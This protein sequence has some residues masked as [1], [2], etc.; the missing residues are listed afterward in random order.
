M[1]SLFLII[2]QDLHTVLF[3]KFATLIGLN[4]QREKNG[5]PIKFVPIKTTCENSVNA[6]TR[7]PAIKRWL[8]F[9]KTTC[10]LLDPRCCNV[11][12]PKP[13]MATQCFL[14]RLQFFFYVRSRN[15]VNKIS[16]PLLKKAFKYLCQT[17]FHQWHEMNKQ[18]PRRAKIA[19]IQWFFS[20][21][22]LQTAGVCKRFFKKNATR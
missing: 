7:K 1:W 9:W 20:T 12:N 11:L 15:H 17:V 21:I 14:C 22:L 4:Y 6:V 13:R 10:Q 18:C 19:R 8:M 16:F 5:S 3:L 2:V